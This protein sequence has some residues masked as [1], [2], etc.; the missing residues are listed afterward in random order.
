MAVVDGYVNITVLDAVVPFV[1]DYQ[2]FWLG[3]GTVAWT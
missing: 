1:S 3:L 2:P